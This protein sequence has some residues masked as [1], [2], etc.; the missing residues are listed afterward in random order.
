VR[1]RV[2]KRETRVW[3][4]GWFTSYMRATLKCKTVVGRAYDLISSK[5]T[6]ECL[7]S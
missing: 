6:Y 4:L 1:E 7:K 3:K 5:K 2:K